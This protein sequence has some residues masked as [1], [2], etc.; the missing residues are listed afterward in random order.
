MNEA[1]RNKAN[2]FWANL[3]LSIREEPYR[4]NLERL[5]EKRRRDMG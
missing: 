2:E 3:D 5:I 4:T 1:Q